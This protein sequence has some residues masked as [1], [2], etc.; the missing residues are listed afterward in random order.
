MMSKLLIRENRKKNCGKQ[1]LKRNIKI[2]TIRLE[3]FH[4]IYMLFVGS[5]TSLLQKITQ[6]D[7]ILNQKTDCFRHAEH[8]HDV[9]MEISR[10]Y[11]Q[12]FLTVLGVGKNKENLW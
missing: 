8:N 4:H 3:I 5:D 7:K 12:L 2:S 6:T 11:C 1:K 9:N 10:T